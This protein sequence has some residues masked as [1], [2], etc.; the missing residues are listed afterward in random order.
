TDKQIQD[1]YG[2]AVS[3]VVMVLLLLLGWILRSIL[4]HFGIKCCVPVRRGRGQSDVENPQPRDEET[5]P[6]ERLEMMESTGAGTERDHDR[7]LP[8]GA[9]G[10]RPRTM[11]PKKLILTPP[12]YYLRSSKK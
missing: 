4:G 11:P 9:K 2:L 12:S 7:P 1:A 5:R 8:P 6:K 3:A 10:G